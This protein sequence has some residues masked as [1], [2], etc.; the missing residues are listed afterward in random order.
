ME[1]LLNISP[2][3]GRYKESTKELSEYFSEY[4]LIK[5]RVIIEIKWL[6]KLLE[7]IGFHLS[8]DE[9]NSF[10]SILDNFNVTEAIKVKE[11][12][13]TTKHDVKAVE[14]YLR[15]K[16]VELDLDKYSCYIHFACTSEDINNL[17]YNLMIKNAIENSFLANAKKLT[18]IVREKAIEWKSV[19]ML[20]HTHGQPA[21]PTTIGKELAVFVYRWES[22]LKMLESIKLKGKFSGA[23]GNFNAHLVAFPNFDWISI[24]KNFIEELGLEYNPLT[25]QIESHDTLSIV[26]NYIR[27]FNNITMDFNSD[28]WLYIS[29]SYFK[30]SVVK[31]EVGSSVMPHKVNPIN[32]ENSMAN[33]RIANSIFSTLSDNLPVSRM[34]RDLSDS[35]SLRNIGSGFAHSL[36]SI[37]QTIIGFEKMIV[38]EENI[39]ADLK[40]NCAVLAE[41]IQTILRKNGYANAYE[42]LKE[43][44]RGNSAI[45]LETFKDFINKLEINQEDKNNLLAL[46]PETY[47]GIADKLVDFI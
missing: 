32:H 30:Q 28:M 15:N 25:T 16:F 24:S 41:P 35:S 38:N 11:I 39:S 20:A 36:V 37:K 34:Q 8:D 42:L 43:L 2:I 21:S 17:A 5:Y 44:T 33:I 4:A 10:N 1:E 23:V 47:I 40:N 19:P 13:A 3:D 26:F 14:Y 12:E 9:L 6:V 45:T 31:N 22:I 29:M 46:N 27:A 7:L 18:S